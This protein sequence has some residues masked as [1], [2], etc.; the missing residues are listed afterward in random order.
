MKLRIACIAAAS[1]L[2]TIVVSPFAV[3]TNAGDLNNALDLR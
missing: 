3:R 2:G 1:V